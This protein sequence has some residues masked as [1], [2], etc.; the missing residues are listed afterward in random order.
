[1]CGGGVSRV[2]DL[3]FFMRNLSNAAVFFWG[4]A[5]E[6][7]QHCVRL[8]SDKTVTFNCSG[9]KR[10]RVGG[11]YVAKKVGVEQWLPPFLLCISSMKR[12]RHFLGW[13]GE[14]AVLCSPRN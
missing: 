13:R 5:R 2:G 7:T 10:G 1:M 4:S 3:M 11:V 6:F 12:D 8:G 14:Y 9:K